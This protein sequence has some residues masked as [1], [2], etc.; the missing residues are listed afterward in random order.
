MTK[1]ENMVGDENFAILRSVEDTPGTE[2]FARELEMNA[3]EA[4]VKYINTL[5]N[6]KSLKN[7]RT[8]KG[9]TQATISVDAKKMPWFLFHED[10]IDVDMSS[11]KFTITNYGGLSKNDLIK[12]NKFFSSVGK[13]QSLTKNFGV[14][15]VANNLAIGQT[16]VMISFDGKEV[17][18]VWCGIKDGVYSFLND[19]SK[20][21]VTEDAFEMAKERGWDMNHPWT[22]VILIGSWNEGNPIEI[23]KCNT[24]THPYGMDEPQVSSYFYNQKFFQRF[25]D[26]DDRIEIRLSPEVQT[27]DFNIYLRTFDEAYKLAEQSYKGDPTLAPK[28]E[29]VT[30]GSLKI[31]YVHNPINDNDKSGRTIIAGQ[32][33]HGLE[34]G[35]LSLVHGEEGQ[36]E[37]YDIKTNRHSVVTFLSKCGIFTEHKCFHIFVEVPF[38]S[39]RIGTWRDI[40]RTK[41]KKKKQVTMF[42]YLTQIRE[43]MPEW[44]MK[45]VEYYNNQIEKK[46]IAD[47][48]SDRYR[49][50]H[51][52]DILKKTSEKEKRQKRTRTKERIKKNIK[53]KVGIRSRN[54]KKKQFVLSDF[55][56]IPFVNSTALQGN[57]AEFHPDNNGGENDVIYVDNTHPIIDTMV[58][59]IENQP[60]FLGKQTAFE[61][62]RGEI[63]DEAFELLKV[64]VAVWVLHRKFNLME[65]N[66]NNDEFDASI[67]PSVIT[68]VASQNLYEVNELKEF[69]KKIVKTEEDKIHIQ[70]SLEDKTKL[71]ENNPGYRAPTEPELI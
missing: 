7:K 54:G 26:F 59:K 16:F 70:T 25:V 53:K 37:R 23:M 55:T 15:H 58:S 31:R 63:Y 14:G 44:F 67:L 11:K 47:R 1:K 5:D 34:Y 60:Y 21:D 13:T 3:W 32:A 2:M 27:Q 36:K 29:T 43:N 64:L 30:V 50:L 41:C 65:G 9:I 10:D 8:E 49:A 17:N 69:A 6:L 52:N 22:E 39:V 35:L 28:D 57:F 62:V 12:A 68:G 40:L 33:Q 66:I 56:K 45:Q 4:T 18:Y 71:W 42:D 51:P 19:L 38:D 48:I 61:Q 20:T 46:D 24:A